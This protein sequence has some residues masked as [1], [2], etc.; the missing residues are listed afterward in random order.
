MTSDL[1]ILVAK[2]TNPGAWA[3]DI[4]DGSVSKIVRELIE[5]ERFQSLQKARLAIEAVADWLDVQDAEDLT[6]NP[7]YLLQK[8]L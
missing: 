3:I 7:V 2:N 8:Q 4:T 5:R 1:V 6:C